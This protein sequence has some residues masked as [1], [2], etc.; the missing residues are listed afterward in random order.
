MAINLPIISEW[1]PK[2]IDKAIADFKKLETNG[3]KAAFAIK[4]A[5]VPAG[6]A[7]AALGTVAFDA[8]KAFAE[9]D[10]AAQK[11]GTTLKNVTYATDDQIASVEQFITKTSMAAAVADD[12]LRPAL[13]KL[14]RGTG[15][16]AQAQD[17]LSLALD[18]SAGTGKDLGAVSDAL[19]KAYNGNFTA[20]KKL[21]PA[22]AALIEEGADA[23]DVFGRLAG[24]FENQASTAANTTQGKMKNLAI[25]MGE[26]KESIGQAVVPL[27]NKLLPKLLEF[28]AWAQ[29]N[30]KLI[31]TIGAVIG[32]IAVA[33]VAVNT[34]MKV[35]TAVTKAFTAVQAAFNAVMAL[36]PIFLIAIAIAGIIAILIVLQQKFNIFGKTI[37]AIGKAFGAVW[38]AIKFVFDWVKKNWPLLLAV[39]TGPFGL[40][41][42]AVVTF[43]DQIT[44][45]LGNLIGWIGTAFKTV[46]DLILFPYIKAFEGIVYF[47]DL[48]ISIFKKLTELGGSI[49][50]NVGGAFKDVINKVIQSLESGLNFAIDGLN[51][52]LDGID[53]AAGPLV[54]FGNI[55]RVDIPELA[56]GGIVTG[57][58]LAMI[59]EGREPEAIIPLSKLSSMGFGGG[60][61]PTINITVT[62][63]DPNAVVAALQRYVRMSGPVPVT[64][65]PL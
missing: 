7:I 65:R 8:V 39:I 36:N 40:A 25:Q 30:K 15:D 38:D 3:E 62:S 29:K 23:D 61:G 1:N 44:G 63:A 9:D 12:E 4:K 20:L 2:G 19:S 14:V 43:K 55:D 17:L 35:W 57:P 45:I 34:A 60:G 42:L 32:G 51:L 13:D 37:E 48:V 6:L 50:D 26:L 54:N 11:L 41:V 24:T 28:A 10:A 31:V 64:T 58:T 21:D 27:A 46:T 16:V 47:K 56:E 52:A 22:L 18:I 5:A 49:F 59:G 53:K 33:V